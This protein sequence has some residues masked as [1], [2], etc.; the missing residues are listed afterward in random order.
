MQKGG[1][2]NSVVLQN[3]FPQEI[4]SPL[5]NLKKSYKTEKCTTESCG[6]HRNLLNDKEFR[7]LK[8]LKLKY[9]RGDQ[10]SQ[11]FY[12]IVPPPP[13]P[14]PKKLSTTSLI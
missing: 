2:N 9:R 13:P 14:P 6:R 1:P 4:R 12:K 7:S 10:I 3:W 5:F 8:S 11:P